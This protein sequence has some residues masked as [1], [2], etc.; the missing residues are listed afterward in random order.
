MSTRLIFLTA[1]IS[2][3]ATEASYFSK[4]GGLIFFPLPL[5][6][7]PV[8]CGVPPASIS[9]FD[10]LPGGGIARAGGDDNIGN[11]GRLPDERAVLCIVGLLKNL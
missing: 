1:L 4:Y 7:R 11:T 2:V 8:N 10:I 6:M 9:V 3:V 5:V